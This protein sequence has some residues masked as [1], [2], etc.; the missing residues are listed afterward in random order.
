MFKYAHLEA[1]VN[2]Q[3]VMNHLNDPK[4]RIIEAD[5]SPEAYNNAH[6][7]NAVFWNILSDLLLP[8]YRIN[9]D[10][11]AWEK[12]LARS[13]VSKDT[14]V[15]TY[16]DYGDLP[17]TGAWLFWLFKVFGHGN[18][19]VLNG[20]RRKW[21]MEGLPLTSEAP[22]IS[23]TSYQVSALDANLRIFHQQVQ[24]SI[25]KTDCVLVD[26]RT[27]QEYNGEWFMNEPPKATERAGHIPSAVSVFYGLALNDDGTF[28]SMEDL[29]ALYGDK[30]ITP[31][32]QVIT[33]CAIGGRSGHTWF[34]LKYLLGYPHVQNYDGS[35][36]E[37]S[38]LANLPIEK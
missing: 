26:V 38:R 35:W 28:K 7:P 9:F 22:V 29:Q 32:H 18:V 23:P 8:D 34:V 2:C 15:I 19:R 21:L 16:G 14:T 37:W 24:E 30:N 13:G 27:P 1:L 10:T 33:Y 17:A 11:T 12:L 25:G 20:G 6:I 31:E 5:I 3:W 36:N 4:V